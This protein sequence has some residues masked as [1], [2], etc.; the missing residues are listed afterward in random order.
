[1]GRRPL[2]PPFLQSDDNLFSCDLSRESCVK[3]GLHLT[4]RS[5]ELDLI[6]RLSLPTIV[7][8]LRD[9]EKKSSIERAKF[10][11]TKKNEKIKWYDMVNPHC[12][13]KAM[14]D[15]LCSTEIAAFCFVNTSL[16]DVN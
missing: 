12:V 5:G 7:E 16:I 1:M 9:C 4:P 10:G 11:S 6:Q 8:S 2:A 15:L 14:Q 3:H 13:G